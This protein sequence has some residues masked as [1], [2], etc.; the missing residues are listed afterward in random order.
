M[1]G[2]PGRRQVS[3]YLDTPEMSFWRGGG[4]PLK[5][6]QTGPPRQPDFRVSGYPENG[7]Q[8]G[9]RKDHGRGPEDQTPKH[10]GNE[11]TI[12]ALWRKPRRLDGIPAE[13]EKTIKGFRGLKRGYRKNGGT[14]RG[15]TEKPRG[16]DL[17]RPFRLRWFFPVGRGER[18]EA[19]R[20]AAG[21]RR[22][23]FPNP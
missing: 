10:A 5:N 8:G 19:R 22:G 17:K 4:T 21:G 11:K 12:K 18:P 13:M 15:R 9:D 20:K 6:H 23:R 3:G 16:S 2:T 14:P 7:L 1:K